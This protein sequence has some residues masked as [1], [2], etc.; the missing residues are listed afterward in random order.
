MR[1]KLIAVFLAALV[2]FAM[3][4][5]A[6]AQEFDPDRVGSISVTLADPANQTPLT[7]VELAFKTFIPH[8]FGKPLFANPNA[9]TLAVAKARP[10]IKRSFYTDFIQ[11]NIILSYVL[12]N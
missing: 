1:H 12:L 11:H 5:T 10:R 4:I 3:P 6:S 8:H 7:G 2:F 9:T